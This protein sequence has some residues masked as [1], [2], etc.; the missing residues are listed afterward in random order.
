MPL[1]DHFHSSAKV[2]WHSFHHAWASMIAFELNHHLP[3]DYAAAPSIQYRNEID[4]AVYSDSTLSVG[5][6]LRESAVVEYQAAQSNLLTA[7]PRKEWKSPPP[8]RSIGFDVI[9][10]IFEVLVYETFG[11]NVLVGAIELISPANKDRPESRRAFVAKCEAI[12]RAGIGLILVDIVPGRRAN[13]H[14]ELMS[15]IGESEALQVA[16]TLYTTAYRAVQRDEQSNLDIWAEQLAL[17]EP[18]T[19][20]PLWLRGGIC[21]PVDL[22]ATYQRTCEEMRIPAGVSSL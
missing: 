13:L 21:I 15:Q 17:G 22:D 18:L 20:M 3:Q 10:I 6:T 16:D 8:L 11:G 5:Q 2:Q 12:L 4:V 1:L 9:D 7:K 19:T 14:N